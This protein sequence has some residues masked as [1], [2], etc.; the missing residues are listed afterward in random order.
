MP[1]RR[2]DSAP[3][4]SLAVHCHCKGSH[5]F[6]GIEPAILIFPDLGMNLAR[7][8][9]ENEGGRK[10]ERKF[11]AVINDAALDRKVN[12]LKFNND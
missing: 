11:M 10:R 12:S 3:P 9:R 2:T 1:T 4:S 8:K 5:G 6:R 7:K